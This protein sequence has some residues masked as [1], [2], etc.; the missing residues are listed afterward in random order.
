M[1]PSGFLHVKFLNSGRYL[2]T[3]SL[4]SII[5]LSFRIIKATIVIG[6]DIDQMGK[7]EF[8]FIG[9]PLV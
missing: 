1:D 2:E 4:K 8:S 9:F 6:F 7:I 3:L 5:P